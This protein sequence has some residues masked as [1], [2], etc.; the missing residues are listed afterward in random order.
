MRK[1]SRENTWHD[2]RIPARSLSVPFVACK[3]FNARTAHRFPYRFLYIYRHFLRN[4]IIAIRASVRHFAACYRTEFR[5]FRVRA[6][7]LPLTD[8]HSR[9]LVLVT[10]GNVFVILIFISRRGSIVVDRRRYSEFPPSSAFRGC[11]VTVP[12][13]HHSYKKSQFDPTNTWEI[14]K[15]KW[16][17][18][19]ESSSGE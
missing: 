18:K 9:L 10:R 3:K 6:H 1:K 15:T 16:T 7:Y 14:D 17:S 19:A 13:H 11:Q 4:H 2:Q 5:V 12:G 8:T